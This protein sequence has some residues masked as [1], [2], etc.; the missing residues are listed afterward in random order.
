MLY[1]GDCLEIMPLLAA[2]SIDAIICDLPF[3]L[4]DAKWDSCIPLMLLWSQYRRIA[5]RNTAIVLHSIQPFTSILLMSNPGEY[6][7]FWVWNK[8]QSGSFQTAKY[9]P[10]KITEDVL[11]FAFGRCPYEPQ[12]RTGIARHKGG[13]KGKNELASGIKSGHSTFNNQYY[14]TNLIEMVNPRANKLHPTQKPVE[15]AEYLIRTYTKPGNIILDNCMGSGTTGVACAN[16]GRRF[17][18]IEKD[19]GYFKIAQERILEA[20][21]QNALIQAQAMGA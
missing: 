1:F 12:M 18:G 9:M 6:K 17:I 21:F 3:G 13:A 7:H 10:L 4:T 19:P 16:T 2:N 5:K 11:I 14:P 15:L 8:K 20:E